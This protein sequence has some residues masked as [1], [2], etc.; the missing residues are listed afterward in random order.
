MYVCIY[1]GPQLGFAVVGDSAEAAQD[2]RGWVADARELALGDTVDL[3]FIDTRFR[4]WGL[5]FGVW[6]LGFRW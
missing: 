2:Y 1:I 6:G 5:G 3:L 4:V